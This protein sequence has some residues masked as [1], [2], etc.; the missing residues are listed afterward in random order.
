MC[1]IKLLP[2][3]DVIEIAFQCSCLHFFWKFCISFHT[4]FNDILKFVFAIP[5]TGIIASASIGFFSSVT[6][7]DVYELRIVCQCLCIMGEAPGLPW[8]GSALFQSIYSLKKK[9][10]KN[11]APSWKGLTILYQFS[12]VNVTPFKYKGTLF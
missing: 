10:N 2:F 8:W 9:Q 3:A 4:L 6:L 1:C 11:I 7:F 12:Q 5:N